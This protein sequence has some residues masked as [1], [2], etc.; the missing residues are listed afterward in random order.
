V[1]SERGLAE[2]RVAAAL[3]HRFA[4]VA[5]RLWEGDRLLAGLGWEVAGSSG[6]TTLAPCGFRAA[7]RQA[8]D[9]HGQGRSQRFLD[10]KGDPAVQ[11][12]VKAPD[13]CWQSGI[14]R[15]GCPDHHRYVFGT[16]TEPPRCRDVVV[17]AIDR[18]PH[19]DLVESIGILADREMR[20]SVV[21]AEVPGP[22][23][24]SDEPVAP[25]PC[26]ELVVVELMESIMARCAAES[27]LA[28]LA[29]G[30][31]LPEG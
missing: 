23:T 18:F 27:L 26:T 13:R 12:G 17:D 30:S 22:V 4:E 7:V 1:L 28:R 2:M 16:T 20:V 14:L 5:V 24:A 9:L 6:A 29:E 15:L 25:F 8:M 21:V 11:L 10:A 3:A 19:D 31:L